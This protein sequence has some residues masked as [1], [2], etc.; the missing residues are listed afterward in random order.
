MD[1]AA[2]APP[3]RPVAV[4]T[5]SQLGL[6]DLMVG[7]CAALAGHISHISWCVC[8]GCASYSAKEGRSK[9]GWHSPSWWG[10]WG[11]CLETAE[12]QSKTRRSWFEACLSR[13]ESV[14]GLLSTP[15]LKWAPLVKNKGSKTALT[16]FI[17]FSHYSS[18]MRTI[19]ILYSELKDEIL[20]RKSLANLVRKLPGALTLADECTCRVVSQNG[21]ASAN[22]RGKS[23]ELSFA[24]I[25]PG[26]LLSAPSIDQHMLE[27]FLW[28]VRWNNANHVLQGRKGT[29]E[30]S[31]AWVL[32]IKH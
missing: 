26:N 32:G 8:A 25:Y 11:C 10:S 14:H 19:N 23:T 12:T 16:C 13:E 29:P 7:Q 22:T 28:L 9:G 3:S 4:V 15:S 20:E 31:A 6:Q 2:C 17:H 24:H 1:S 18:V 21:A 5:T 30:T 27:C